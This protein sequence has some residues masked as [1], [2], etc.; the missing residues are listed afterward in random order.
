M[1]PPYPLLWLRYTAFIPLYPLGVASEMTMAYLALPVI[2]AK[3]PLS[4]QL[5]NS[6]NWGMDYYWC[7]WLIILG[8]L[9]GGR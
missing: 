9:P 8:Y 2:K 7:C 1:T 6:F 5:P 4:V 3:R